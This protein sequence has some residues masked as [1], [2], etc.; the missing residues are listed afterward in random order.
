MEN[1]FS[2]FSSKSRCSIWHHANTLSW[3]NFRTQIC[4][5]MLTI[6][7]FLLITLRCVTWNDNISNLNSSYSFTNTFNN[8]CC[9]MSQNTRKFSFRIMSIKSINISMTKCIWNDFNSNLSFFRRINI[10]FL[11]NEW[12][13]SLIS[14]SSFTKNW[15]T[16]E[17]LHQ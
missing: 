11:N 16:L 10:N 17:T 7:T 6:N 1:S 12:F 13:F 9:L 15:F 3:S 5:L 14:N 8:S 2:L 4:W